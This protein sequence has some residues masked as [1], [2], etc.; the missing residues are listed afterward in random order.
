MWAPNLLQRLSRKENGAS[1]T[2]AGWLKMA[3]VKRN[4]CISIPIHGSFQ[5][6][7][8]IWIGQVGPPAKCDLDRFCNRC[9]I[10]KHMADFGPAYTASSQVLRTRKH[11]LILENQWH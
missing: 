6:H 5:D 3:H 8:I 9:K 11:S 1:K 7:V 10:V 2:P 4:D